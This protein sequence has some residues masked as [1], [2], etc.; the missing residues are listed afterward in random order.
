MNP[1][2]RR[3]FTAMQ[4]AGGAAAFSPTSLSGLALYYDATKISGFSNNDPIGTL[5][6]ISS[7]AWQ[8]TQGTASK[9]PTYLTNI[10]NGQPVI[11]FDGVDD[12]LTNTTCTSFN[13]L[14]GATLFYAYKFNNVGSAGLVSFS[15]DARLSQQ[16]FSGNHNTYADGSSGVPYPYGSYAGS[17]A[18]QLVEV[19]FDGSQTGNADRLKIW[20]DGVAKTLSFTDTIPASFFSGSDG[21]ELGGGLGG[22]YNGHD[23]AVLCYYGRALTSGERDQVRSYINGLYAI[24]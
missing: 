7:N 11:R 18:W 12:I 10:K 1:F 4:G 6:D 21:F 2:R 14:T 15:A 17:S 8:A 3:Q 16:D 22:N 19:V 20:V 9:K 13:G 5:T 24:Y 23:L